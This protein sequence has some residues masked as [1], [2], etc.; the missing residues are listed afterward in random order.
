MDASV[1]RA[2]G[3][4][5]GFDV[6]V[7][8]AKCDDQGIAISS[9]AIRRAVAYGELSAA[10]AML[11]RRYSVCGTVVRGSN[12][13]R[14]IGVPTINLE[15][16]KEKLLPPDGVYAVQV[17]AAKGSFGG[18]MN[19]GGRPTFGEV[20]RVP[21]IHLFGG[22]GDWYGDSVRVEFVA[23]L[24]DT[25]RFAGVKEL[26]EQLARDADAARLALTQA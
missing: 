10:R 25:V 19:L 18:M 16:P 9:T 14:S 3:S 11:G 13:G 6:E 1:L 15:L 8:P 20:E 5:L 2:L 12:R 7:I 24:R 22:S 26:I 23:K 21:E 4:T 17:S